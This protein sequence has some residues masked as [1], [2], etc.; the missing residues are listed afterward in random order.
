MPIIGV[1][2]EDRNVP[3]AVVM[4]D[5]LVHTHPRSKAARAYMK[6]AAKLIGKNDYND[7]GFWGRLFG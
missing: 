6:V 5:A 1:I 2:P 4:K 7:S 3:K